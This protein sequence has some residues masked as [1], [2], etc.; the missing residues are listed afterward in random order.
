M[1][2][3]VTNVLGGDPVTVELIEESSNE[4]LFNIDEGDAEENGEAKYQL[5][6]GC[7]YQYSITKGFCL[8]S[9]HGIVQQFIKENHLGRIIPGNYVG[10]LTL[11]II[12]IESKSVVGSFDL[13]VRSVKT[14]YR[15]DYRNML[16]EITE[17]CIDILMQPDSPASQS[18]SSDFTQTS[19]S[20]YQKFAF[21]KS[22]IDSEEFNNAIH[23]FI[24]SPTKRWVEFEAE[25][26]VYS[27]KRL[28][29]KEVKQ[30]CN[31]GNLS[32]LPYRN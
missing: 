29:Q 1:L 9:S 11:E 4:T 24:Y 21:I 16:E 13:E 8:G 23:K 3:I 28:R 5:V 25:K 20:L 19:N 12:K 6:E 22:I 10:R 18:F 15:H 26:N 32:K 31:A 14:S 17:A 2:T 30:L 27:L 7:T